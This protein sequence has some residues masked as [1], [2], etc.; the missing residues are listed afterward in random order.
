VFLTMGTGTITQ[1]IYKQTQQLIDQAF[2]LGALEAK[3]SINNLDRNAVRL[4]EDIRE[5]HNEALRLDNSLRSCLVNKE[6]SC[7]LI[8]IP[9]S[10]I[11]Q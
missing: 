1:V 11:F 4:Q 9:R 6:N 5:I 8:D 2:K 10:S 3:I 7:E